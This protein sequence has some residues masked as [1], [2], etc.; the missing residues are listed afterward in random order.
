MKARKALSAPFRGAKALSQM[1]FRRRGWR[2][3]GVGHHK[4]REF[5]KAVGDGTH[6]STVM[7]PL[8]W[9]MRTF[10]EAPP[11]VWKLLDDG[12][13]ERDAK[14]DMVRLLE[15]PNPYYT[16]A[17]LWMAT[18]LDWH[19][20]GNAYWIKVRD[21][22]D[23]VR[24]LWW[25]PAST[26]TPVGDAGVFIDHFDY[27]P[28]AETIEL[29]PR[30]VVHFRYGLDPDDYRKGKS[31]LT[32]VLR[33]VFTDEEA[34]EFTAHLLR[35]HGVPGL[36]VSPEG[37][38][39][40]PSQDDV[41]ATKSLLRES[42]S[43]ER[44]GEPLVMSSPTK[45]QQFGFSPEQMN[46]RALRRIPEERVSAAVGVPAI[47][48][49]LG[50]GLDR[51]TFSN[52]GEAREMAY[53][54]CIIPA[55]RIMGEGLR[56]QLLPDF[57]QQPED[58][59]VGFDISGVRVLQEDRDKVVD[60]A[61]KGV[62]G[63]WLLVNE[64][65]RAAGFDPLDGGDV[66]LRPL[67][68]LE[69]APGEQRVDP[70]AE[71]SSAP[72]ERG[73]KAASQAQTRLIVA[74]ERDSRRLDAAFA[75]ELEAAFGELGDMAADAF[76]GF[77]SAVELSA[78]VGVV[79]TKASDE[80]VAG[81]VVASMAVQDWIDGKLRTTFEGHYRRTAE[82]TVSTINSVLDLGVSLP[83]DVE[84]TVIQRGGTRRGLIDIEQ[85]TRSAIVR[86]IAD[87]RE[88]GDGP[89]EIARRIRDQVPAGRYRNA[90]PAYRAQLIA[91]TET[92]HAQNWSSLSAYKNADNVVAVV[93]FD[94][95]LGESDADC[96]ARN[97]RTFTFDDADREMAQE[98][99]NGTLSFAPLV[100]DTLS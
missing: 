47:V 49:G 45:V 78:G 16:G 43:G 15:R 30:D 90:G 70:A 98:H 88:A 100:A 51:S 29:E 66:Y 20:A 39:V 42:H 7:A 97:G 27:K 10:P 35:N 54:G 46:L 74:L 85:S 18:M 72:G 93:A 4:L 9:V 31:P 71:L 76:A 8:L 81:Q 77:E 12:Q 83:D 34:A 28:N 48:A 22:G 37:D 73:T 36:V 96:E 80:Q 69:M 40:E 44:R 64:G 33:E 26:I 3:F 24:E 13:E 75:D 23:R 17:D 60:R 61:D 95:R 55:Q 50:A 38:G 57:E 82:Q 53:E 52:M 67:G 5:Q 99:P 89:P 86:A 6:A 19:A 94:A 32:S 21:R 65:R 59:R 87:G 56:W 84:Q 79:E 14:H 92:K 25:A 91:R 2:L 63:G 68:A 58:Y 1:V 41:D 11:A 62:R